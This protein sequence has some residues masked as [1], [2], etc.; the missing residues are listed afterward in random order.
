VNACC[1]EGA[2]YTIVGILKAMGQYESCLDASGELDIPSEPEFY[3]GTQMFVRRAVNKKS[4][5]RNPDNPDYWVQAQGFSP[6][7]ETAG[8]SAGRSSDASLLP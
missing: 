5:E 1:W 8:A 3:L 7:K 2:L 6:F 4:K